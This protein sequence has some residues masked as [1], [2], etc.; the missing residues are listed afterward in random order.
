MNSKLSF[1]RKWRC[2]TSYFVTVAS[3]S[4]ICIV[5]KIL[6]LSFQLPGRVIAYGIFAMFFVF[7]AARHLDKEDQREKN[8]TLSKKS[9]EA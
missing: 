5:L 7:L 1:L 6:P 2:T 3:L 8:K 4:L 9:K